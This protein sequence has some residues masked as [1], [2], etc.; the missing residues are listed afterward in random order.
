MGT[1]GRDSLENSSCKVT[2]SSGN[3]K[4]VEECVHIHACTSSRGTCK[5]HSLSLPTSTPSSLN[6]VPLTPQFVGR[7]TL[8]AP[9]TLVWESRWCVPRHLNETVKC[10]YPSHFKKGETE[11]QRKQVMCPQ[12]QLALSKRSVSSVC[13]RGTT[14]GRQKHAEN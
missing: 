6:P 1:S 13:T 12:S 2:T 14:L 8:V 9:I 10:C 3:P 4:Q 7:T 11:S 5:T